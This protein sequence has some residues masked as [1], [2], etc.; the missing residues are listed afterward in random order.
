MDTC[1]IMLSASGRRVALLRILQ[2][3]LRELGITGSVLATDITATSPAYHV[4]DARCLV[5]GYRAPG[6]L[7]ALLDVC[8]QHQIKLIVPTIDPDLPFYAE[9]RAAFEAIGTRIVI[10]SPDTIDI[11]RDKDRTHAWLVEQDLPTVDQC[12]PEIALENPSDWAF[13]LFVKPRCGSASIGATVV[14]DAD[15]LR[16]ATRGGDCVVQRLAPGVEYTVDVYVDRDGECRCAVPRRRLETRAGEVSKGMT[17][18]CEPVIE[19]ARRVAQSLPG[20]CGVLNI[21]VFHDEPTQQLNVI[22][23]NARFGGGHPLAHAA[24]ATMARWVIQDAMGLP[25]DAHDDWQ[26]GLVMLRYDEAVFVTRE[27]AGL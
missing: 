26:D 18:R 25:N 4:G 24:G 1:H 19:L 12:A 11:G 7:E 17:V 23:L 6:C 22:E 16:F 15:E 8:K 21:Q 2:D 3:S 13:P 10:S 20:A 14:R 9:H 5:P 27:Q